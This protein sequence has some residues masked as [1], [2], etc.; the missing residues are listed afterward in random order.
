MH[1]GDLLRVGA[2]VRQLF[3]QLHNRLIEGPRGPVIFIT[4]DVIEDAIARQDFVRMADKELEKFYFTRGERKGFL[5]A[6]QLELFGIDNTIAERR[7]AVIQ[8]IRRTV[9]A[10]QRVHACGQFAQAKGLGHVVIRAQIE[11]YD[12]VNLLAF[13]REH[14]DESLISLGAKLLAD[15]VSAQAREHDVE[16]DETG[17]MLVHCGQGLITTRARFHSKAL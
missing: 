2:Y 11:A 7:F 3:S 5:A 8:R 14:E 9:A 6:P 15:I 12:L 16:H 1:S 4:P 10:Q 13:V 17:A